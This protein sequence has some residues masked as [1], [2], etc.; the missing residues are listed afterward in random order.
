M[1]SSAK[2]NSGLSTKKA[3]KLARTEEILRYS[4][5]YPASGKDVKARVK[6]FV[7]ETMDIPVSFLRRA[8]AA[9]RDDPDRVFAPSISE[10]RGAAARVIRKTRLQALGLTHERAPSGIDPQLNV[11]VEIE[12]AQKYAPD[13]YAEDMQAIEADADEVRLTASQ[14][15]KAIDE[16]IEAINEIES[17]DAGPVAGL[18]RSRL[19]TTLSIANIERI[20]GG[21]PLPNDMQ[22]RFIAAKRKVK[23]P[24]A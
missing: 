12:W 11:A 24:E 1:R 18:T 3:D 14:A 5:R 9:F 22:A 8:G 20:K 6:V 10:L 17:F 4:I 15:Y 16:A 2:T 23:T 7:E 13:G 19:S 21:H